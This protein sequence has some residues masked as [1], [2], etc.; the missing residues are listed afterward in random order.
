VLFKKIVYGFDSQKGAWKLRN[1]RKG[2]IKPWNNH[3]ICPFPV[4]GGPGQ[5]AHWSC[6]EYWE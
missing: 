4:V 1:A 2:L 5:G 3:D 6:L